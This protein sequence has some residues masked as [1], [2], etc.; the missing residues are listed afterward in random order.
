MSDRNGQ[1]IYDALPESIKAVYSFREWSFLPDR[2][3][4]D[5]ERYET[6]P[7]PEE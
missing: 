5:L 7:E 3:K 1:A 4:A 6:E 2:Q